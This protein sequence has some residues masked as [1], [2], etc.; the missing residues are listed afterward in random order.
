MYLPFLLSCLNHHSDGL[1]RSARLLLL[2]LLTCAACLAGAASASPAPGRFE[3]LRAQ[4]LRV[5]SVAYRLSIANAARCALVAVPQPGFVLHDIAQYAPADRSDAARAFGL[6]ARPG[7][8]AVVA[9]SPAE[10][11]GLR[12]GD[13][14]HAVNGRALD[15][16]DTGGA[17]TRAAVERA[18]QLLVAAMA[19]G[20]IV[21]RVSTPAGEREVRFAAE[22]GCPSNVELIPGDAVN[23]WADGTRVMVSEGLLRRCATD[24]DLALVIGHEMAHNLMHHRRRLAAE[25][26]VANALLPTEGGSRDMR[27]IRETEEEA[28][29]LA[30]SLAA[31]AAFDLGDAEP[32]LRGLLRGGVAVAA[33]HPAPE[34][35]LALLRAAIADARQGRAHSVTLT[36]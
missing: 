30:V 17:P 15:Q 27:E 4:D 11:A 6:D 3:R 14:L 12:A 1:R 2:N 22:L 16:D 9:G 10:R 31:M 18:E 26:I 20:P 23:A 36:G 19:R 13:R 28:D 24:G 21:L 8:M 32:F 25:G 33:T 7:V 35:R 5:E 34:R 29:R